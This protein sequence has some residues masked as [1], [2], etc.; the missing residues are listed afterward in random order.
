MMIL[1]HF[2]LKTLSRS[3]ISN[4]NI[5]FITHLLYNKTFQFPYYFYFLFYILTKPDSSVHFRDGSVGP[6][7]R[8]R[9]HFTEIP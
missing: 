2:G 3:K 8:C 4:K 6:V 7:S 5:K 1:C 9:E